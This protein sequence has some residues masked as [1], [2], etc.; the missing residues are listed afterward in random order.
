MGFLWLQC[1]TQHL[2]LLNLIQLALAIG[3]S[4]SR[5][6]CRSFLPSSRSTLLPNVVS[7]ANLLRVHSNSLSRSVINV[8]NRTGPNIEP[9]GTPLVTGHQLDLT[10]FTTTLWAQPS[11][12]FFIQRRVRP[13]KPRAV[14]FPRRMLW[15]TVTKALLKFRQ[16]TSTAFLSSTKRDTLSY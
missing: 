13:S 8:F 2:A 10:P 15:E 1:S 4:L 16:T 7:S 9:C 11:S 3:S 5:S 12:Q 6:L 14:T